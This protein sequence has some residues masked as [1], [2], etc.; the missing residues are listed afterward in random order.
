MIDNQ[1]RQ[2]IRINENMNRELKK[3]KRGRGKNYFLVQSL[4]TQH[5]Q[6][7][8][9]CIVSSARCSDATISTSASSNGVAGTAA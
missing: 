5:V 4:K 9:P 2:D 1:L 8:T 7:M 3:Y 6:N